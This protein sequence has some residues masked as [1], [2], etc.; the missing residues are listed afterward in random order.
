MNAL[1]NIARETWDNFLARIFL[2]SIG[3]IW[4]IGT[5]LMKVSIALGQ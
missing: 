4:V 2:L 1:L 3:A 5:L